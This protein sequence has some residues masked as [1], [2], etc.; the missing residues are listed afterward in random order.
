MLVVGA[1]DRR[2][3]SPPTTSTPWLDPQ[4]RRRLL[5]GR[6]PHADDT[7][8]YFHTGGTTGTPKLVRHTHANQVSQAWALRLMGLAGPGKAFLFG[9]PLFHVGGAL[10]QGFRRWPMAAT[11]WCSAPPGGAIR[12]QCATSGAGA[13]PPPAVVWRRAHGAGGG[14]Q[15]PVG[16]NDV[17]SLSCASGGGSAIPVAVIQ[18]Y[19][20]RMHLP[21]LEVYGMTETSSVHTMGYPDM[22][23][24]A[25]SVGRPL[26][27]SRTRVVKLDGEGRL[28]G[29]CAAQR[30]W[31]GGDGRSRRVQRLPERRPQ[32]RRVRRAGLGELGRPRT[33]S[34]NQASCGSPAAPRI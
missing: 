9:L 22:P 27:Y 33:A 26:P 18:A 4:P 28:L 24:Q 31:R 20:D 25:G 34:T 19:E 2:P 16:D 21:V 1:G 8:G 23:R 12:T 29:D 17:S 3:I 10:T 14:M 6:L 5:S 7:A 13:T 15:V 32:P 30:D 11:W